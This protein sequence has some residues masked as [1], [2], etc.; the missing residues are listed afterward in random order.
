MMGRYIIRILRRKREEDK[1][2][3]Q[4]F[5]YELN[6]PGDTVASALRNINSR[7]DLKDASGNKAEPVIWES[8]CMQQ[9][10]GACAMV[11][12]G[13]PGLACGTKLAGFKKPVVKVE[14]LRKFPVIADLMTDRSIL[15]ENLK[16]LRIWLE[17][18]AELS[19]ED[20]DRAFEASECIQCGCCLEVCPNFYCGGTFFGMNGV[21]LANRLL[22]ESDRAE[23]EKAASEYKKHIFNGCGKSLACRDICPRGIDTEK[24]MVNAN[25]LAVWKRRK[26]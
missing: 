25:A 6:S 1:S 22:T 2:Y 14:P 3:W 24:M 21:P 5:E 12:N 7:E 23:Y 18:D 8:S 4:D 17:C 13:R 20:I 11:I 16:T 15:Y 19:R 26:K 10:C 9:K